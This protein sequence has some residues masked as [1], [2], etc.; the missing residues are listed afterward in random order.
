MPKSNLLPKRVLVKPGRAGL[1]PYYSL[2]W[3]SPKHA[4]GIL[5][6]RTITRLDSS[7][8]QNKAKETTRALLEMSTI[9][10][11]YNLLNMILHKKQIKGIDVTR[12]I[13]GV[14]QR[15]HTTTSYFYRLQRS[16]HL[17]NDREKKLIPDFVHTRLIIEVSQNK[18]AEIEKLLDLVP[19][20]HIHQLNKIDE[21]NDVL[22]QYNREQKILTLHNSFPLQFILYYG[23]GYHVFYNMISK[24]GE[25]V[26]DKLFKDHKEKISHAALWALKS[27]ETFFASAYHLYITNRY[28]LKDIVPYLH[29]FL[30]QYLF[31]GYTH[32][33]EVLGKQLVSVTP[34]KRLVF[35]FDGVIHKYSEGYQNGSLYDPPMDGSKETLEKLVTAGY[36]IYI[37]TAR[38]HPAFHDVEEEYK[39][40]VA[41]LDKYGFELDKHY[42]EITNNK[43][44][45]KVYIDDNAF[46][47]TNWN[48]IL[49]NINLLTNQ[50]P[51]EVINKENFE[52]IHQPFS[53]LDVLQK[54]DHPPYPS[55]EVIY[56]IPGEITPPGRKPYRGKLGG[57]GHYPG[58]EESV[59]K[60][61]DTPA[62][63][64]TEWI[65]PKKGQ[66]TTKGGVRIPK[67]L[68]GVL[69]ATSKNSPVQVIGKDSKDRTIYLRLAKSIEKASVEKYKR[70]K[71][72]NQALPR[73][74]KRINKDLKTKEEA[75]ILYLISRTGFRI[76]S[77]TETLGAVKAY[78][79]T[80]LE[81][82]HINIK[83]NEITFDFIGKKGVHIQKTVEDD[84]LLMILHKKKL[85]EN[86][87]IFTT[88]GNQVRN[89]L[90]HI[91][92]GKFTPKDFRTSIGTLRALEEIEKRP[93][94]ST[95]AAFKKA[96]REV[97]TVVSQTLGNT[98]GIALTSYIDPNVFTKWKI[99]SGS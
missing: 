98:P 97:A 40:I 18:R 76:G 75:Q 57:I 38:L 58:K 11:Q 78:G 77:T 19:E 83:N 6:E 32:Q 4:F 87:P 86:T 81:G 12:Q 66:T 29:N 89:Y 39:K 43:P 26:L 74:M 53:D 62:A 48:N 79:T 82:Q 73:L 31:V 45:A 5:D 42:H 68:T 88:T 28:Y 61:I 35:D 24:W 91:S 72:F 95:K 17:L 51:I 90:S 67:H 27:D 30:E 37:Q 8:V 65:K 84:I 50:H 70:G 56:E 22:V 55:E 64:Q 44:P 2:R 52:Q 16:Q 47:F 60:V 33:E 25:K 99:G 7:E 63:H 85:K 20:E 10:A 9:L 93:M 46:R 96:R 59:E 15:I 13:N 92:N 80:T 23:I 94:P 3:V 49:S 69:I 21:R 1:K 41:W 14:Q 54:Q 36:Q 34:H 71:L